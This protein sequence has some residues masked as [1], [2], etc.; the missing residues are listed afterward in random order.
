MP[1]V[2]EKWLFT[3]LTYPTIYILIPTKCRELSER[4]L[5]EKP[6]RTTRLIHPQSCTF[7]SSNSFTLTLS[8]DIP[9]RGVLAK[10]LPHHIHINENV[11][12][13]NPRILYA[14]LYG[15]QIWSSSLILT[16]PLGQIYSQS[17]KKVISNVKL[18]GL[19]PK[20]VPIEKNLTWGCFVKNLILI[21][22]FL[23]NLVF[24]S[25]DFCV[26]WKYTI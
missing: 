15:V 22:Y 4:I 13:S 11:I 25:W 9:L 12:W 18:K 24:L 5:R 6:Q 20:K 3:F 2:A 21:H 16:I 23:V 17:N 8:I 14:L 26:F 10:P 19:G 1:C 7:D